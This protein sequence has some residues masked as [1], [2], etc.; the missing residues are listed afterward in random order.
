MWVTVFCN[1]H[2][3]LIL[4]YFLVL[5]LLRFYSKNHCG[6]FTVQRCRVNGA[7]LIHIT[8]TCI[9]LHLLALSSSSSYLIMQHAVSIMEVL[10]GFHQYLC[11]Y[12]VT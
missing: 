9:I 5:S 12:P 6:L 2:S 3:Q 8:Y 7:F 4:G 11:S 10:C 1:D